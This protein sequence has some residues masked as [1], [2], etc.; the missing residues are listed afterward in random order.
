MWK[1][2]ACWGVDGRP[3][4]S[5]G[6]FSLCRLWSNFKPR[7][8]NGGADLIL[9]GRCGV[10]CLRKWGV[11][12]AAYMEMRDY[13]PEVVLTSR[14]SNRDLPALFSINPLPID[15]K[16]PNLQ[17]GSVLKHRTCTQTNCEPWQDYNYCGYYDND[18]ADVCLPAAE[19]QSKTANAPSG[20][21]AKWMMVLLC[22]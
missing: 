5:H 8:L 12:P 11:D 13:Y 9:G 17:F 14:V 20:T 19:M 1:R 10:K 3:R 15:A 4:H 2:C 7:H 18:R 16:T 22:S 21:R 6:V